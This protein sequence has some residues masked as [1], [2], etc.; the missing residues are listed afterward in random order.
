[1]TLSLSC[2]D[3]GGFINSFFYISAY[4]TANRLPVQIPN[5]ITTVRMIDSMPILTTCDMKFLQNTV[6]VSLIFCPN[7]LQFE[8][9][10]IPFAY[11]MIRFFSVL[12]DSENWVTLLLKLSNISLKLLFCNS[13]YSRLSSMPLNTFFLLFL[14][15]I[16]TLPNLIMLLYARLHVWRI[17][18]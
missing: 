14:K 18:T 6:F 9:N 11:E 8:A 2:S 10:F 12:V 4:R 15:S 1:M 17:L 3:S 7:T 16:S 13:S 5:K